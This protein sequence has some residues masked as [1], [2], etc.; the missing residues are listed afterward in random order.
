MELG[1]SR[2]AGQSWA[3]SPMFAFHGRDGLRTVRLIISGPRNKE[4]NET[5]RRPSLPK[6]RIRSL[7]IVLVLVLV[8]VLET[9]GFCARKK[10]DFT[11]TVL[12]S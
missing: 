11:A 10:T 7:E 8:V 9:L 3:F 5:A 2:Y 1:I 6:P 12:C 4:K